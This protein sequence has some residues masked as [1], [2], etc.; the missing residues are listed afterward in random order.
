MKKTNKGLVVLIVIAA[1][2]LGSALISK[3]TSVIGKSGLDPVELDE[4]TSENLFDFAWGQKETTPKIKNDYVGVLYIRGVITEA[5]RSYNQKWVMKTLNNFRKDKKNK[6]I[7]VFVESPGGSVYE[8]DET[9]LALKEFKKVTGR[10]VYAYFG[11]MAASGGYYIGCSADKIFANRNCLTGS[12]GVIA[13]QS[14]DATALFEKL[15]VKV[16]TIHSGKNKI[17]GSYSEKFTA[18]QKEIMQ[19]ISDEAYEQFTGIVSENRNLEINVV[20]KLADGR[21]YTAKQALEHGLID[22]IC[23]LEEA[24][25][26]IRGNIKNDGKLDFVDFKYEYKENLLSLFTAASSFLEDPKASLTEMIQTTGSNVFYL[27]Q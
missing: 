26:F 19:S 2:A 25:N 21:V 8:S 13:G 11:S 3:I 14:V 1:I 18:E 6:G 9:Y 12:I 23:G 10:P 22:E 15:G 17:M 16:T 5:G 20:K 4:R 27:Y 24:K 7:L